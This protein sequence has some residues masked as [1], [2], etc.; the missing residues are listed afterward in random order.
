VISGSERF[1]GLVLAEVPDVVGTNPR[2]A[3]ATL[4]RSGYRGVFEGDPVD[5][6]AEPVSVVGQDPRPGSKDFG[7]QLVRLLV[8]RSSSE[9]PLEPP[10]GCV[11]SPG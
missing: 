6:L 1:S 5:D 4:A 8:S 11:N 7:G 3:C 10:P 2:E 9:R